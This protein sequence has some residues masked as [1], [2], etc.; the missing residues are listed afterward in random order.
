MGRMGN[1]ANPTA[2]T[3]GQSD[4]MRQARKLL[5]MAQ[6]GL[7]PTLVSFS[8]RPANAITLRVSSAELRRS[9]RRRSG[10]GRCHTHAISGRAIAL[11][12]Q[13]LVRQFIALQCP[14][15]GNALP[16]LPRIVQSRLQILNNRLGW[17]YCGHGPSCLTTVQHSHRSPRRQAAPESSRLHGDGAVCATPVRSC[18][19]RQHVLG[20]AIVRAGRDPRRQRRTRTRNR[21]GVRLRLE[22]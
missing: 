10:S 12:L 15:G 11:N 4:I 14:P 16:A 18:A 2:S 6:V 5:I 3:M 8:S 9:D 13:K 22:R 17:A 20:H 21:D 7:Y 1:A 19:I